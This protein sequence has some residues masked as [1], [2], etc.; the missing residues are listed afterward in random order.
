MFCFCC[1]SWFAFCLSLHIGDAILGQSRLYCMTGM[2]EYVCSVVTYF[3]CEPF[4]S[5]SAIEEINCFMNDYVSVVFSFYCCQHQF[6]FAEEIKN[7]TIIS[8]HFDWYVN[9]WV[10]GG[11]VNWA[12]AHTKNGRIPLNVTSERCQTLHSHCT[13]FWTGKEV[14]QKA[15]YSCEREGKEKKKDYFFCVCKSEFLSSLTKNLFSS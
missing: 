7:M 11:T 4:D 8:G 6:L 3:I 1:C 12:V 10:S 15:V 2:C 9:M 14:F 13:C 5:L